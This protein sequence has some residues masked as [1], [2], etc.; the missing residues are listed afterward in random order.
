MAILFVFTNDITAYTTAEIPLH[1]FTVTGNVRDGYSMLGRGTIDLFGNSTPTAFNSSVSVTETASATWTVGFRMQIYFGVVTIPTLPFFQILD[2]A[3]VKLSLEFQNNG[4]FVLKSGAGATLAT[5]TG[6]MLRWT[7]TWIEVQATIAVSGS[8]EVRCNG[9]TELTYSGDTTN[10]G[11]AT[12]NTFKWGSLADQYTT[13]YNDMVLSN[14]VASWLGDVRVDQYRP[15]ADGTY[16]QMTR[17][18]TGVSAW[19]LVDDAGSSDTDYV[20]ASTN[21]YRSTFACANMTHTPS[22]I[23]GLQLVSAVRKGDSAV[24]SV[25]HLLVSGTG[26]PKTETLEGVAYE[27]TTSYTGHITVY[28]NDPSTATAWTVDGVNAVECGVEV[29][30]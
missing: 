22:V 1:G 11:A 13:T 5:G 25:K 15:N 9:R 10:G 18:N 17:S 7:P 4:Q 28:E 8:C 14:S 2:G 21:G 29:V 23:Y 12:A 6:E 19:T 26:S 20:Y 30:L 24:A 16:Q 27:L 3:N